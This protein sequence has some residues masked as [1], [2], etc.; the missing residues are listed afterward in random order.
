LIYDDLGN[1]A[2]ERT[3]VI[4]DDLQ[5]KGYTVWSGLNRNSHVVGSGIYLAIVRVA[6]ANGTTISRSVKIGVKR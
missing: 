2:V 1:V 4:L 6:D 3:D 5:K